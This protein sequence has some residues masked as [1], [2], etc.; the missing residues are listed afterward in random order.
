MKLFEK[1]VI[2]F[3]FLKGASQTF[4]N[5]HGSYLSALAWIVNSKPGRYT[6]GRQTS[7]ASTKLIGDYAA[8]FTRTPITNRTAA[9]VV[10]IVPALA[11]VNVWAQTSIT[12][13]AV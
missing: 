2:H 9:T 1:Q 5:S 6:F 4:G 3:L 13:S 10:H 11:I 7:S 12:Y 8:S